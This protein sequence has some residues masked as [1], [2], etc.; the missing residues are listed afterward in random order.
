MLLQSNDYVDKIDIIDKLLDQSL[1]NHFNPLKLNNTAESKIQT[2][3]G[4]S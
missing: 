2:M 4:L 3:N 1:N